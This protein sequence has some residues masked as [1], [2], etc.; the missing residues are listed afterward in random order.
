MTTTK[1]TKTITANSTTSKTKY[2]QNQQL[3]SKQ[4]LLLNSL[5]PSIH[6]LTPVSSSSSSTFLQRKRKTTNVSFANVSLFSFH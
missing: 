5:S 1:D 4:R 6:A 3:K 2:I